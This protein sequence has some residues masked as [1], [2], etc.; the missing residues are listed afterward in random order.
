MSTNFDKF[1]QFKPL[2]RALF[3]FC[4]FSFLFLSLPSFQNVSPRLA[5]LA[6]SYFIENIE[7]YLLFNNFYSK[8]ATMTTGPRTGARSRASSIA[9][10]PTTG[11]TSWSASMRPSSSFGRSLFHFLY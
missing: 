8:E 11:S 3:S 9:S 4:F 6:S 10:T 5:F 2:L 7:L 1:W